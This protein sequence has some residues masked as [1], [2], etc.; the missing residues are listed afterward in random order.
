MALAGAALL[1]QAGGAFS[2]DHNCSAERA[3]YTLNSDPAFTAGFIPALHSASMAS[4]LYFWIK[5]PQR[6]Y[7]FTFAVSN[8]YSGITLGPVGDPYVAAGDD[9]DNGPV[10]IDVGEFSRRDMRIYPMRSD[11]TV[12]D[13]PPSA[14]DP[15]PPAMFAPE[16]GT[17][18]WYDVRSVTLD[19]TA[20]RDSM[21]RGVF[22]HT[23][24]LGETPKP[25]YP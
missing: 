11:M 2:A 6:T 12:L 8:G 25:A 23:S 24:C 22:L 17:T 16:M 18:L 19:A 10:E 4:N 13:T 1:S 5:S 9:P 3:L 15:P 21:D 20:Q 7:W 14:G